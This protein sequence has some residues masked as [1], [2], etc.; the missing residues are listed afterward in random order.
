[1]SS[2]LFLSKVGP[3]P[4]R[5][6]HY[7]AQVLKSLVC[8]SEENSLNLLCSEPFST[9]LG[10]EFEDVPERK[11]LDKCECYNFYVGQ[12]SSLGTEL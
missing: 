7:K 11:I 6:E 9:M 4:M 8:N 12:F 1:M 2:N 3:T 5:K 10:G